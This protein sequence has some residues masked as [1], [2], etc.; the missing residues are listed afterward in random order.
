RMLQV[1]PEVLDLVRDPV[2]DHVIARR[3]AHLG[4]GELDELGGDGMLAPERVH[5]IDKRR[6]KRVLAAAQQPDFCAHTLYAFADCSTLSRVSSTSDCTTARRSPVW[7][8]TSTW[9][10]ALVPSDR[11]F[12]TY[13]LSRRLSSPSTTSSTKASSSSARSRI[14]TSRR[15][16]KSISLPSMPHRAARHLFSSINAR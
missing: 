15:L 6:R 3:L 2:D 10:S 5:A 12:L 4:A 11:I 13:S 9:R 8:Y 1:R 16:P 14:G 7:R